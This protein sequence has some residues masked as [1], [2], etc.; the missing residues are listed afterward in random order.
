[1][2]FLSCCQFQLEMEKERMRMEI[3]KLEETHHAE[4]YASK[5]V[6]S[7]NRNRIYRSSSELC[8]EKCTDNLEIQVLNMKSIIQKLNNQLEISR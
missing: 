3:N 1:M 4:N 7:Q 2:S 6:E 5:L 8:R